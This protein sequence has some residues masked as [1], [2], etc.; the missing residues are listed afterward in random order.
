MTNLV[1]SLRKLKSAWREGDLKAVLKLADSLPTDLS[2]VQKLR[3]KAALKTEDWAVVSDAALHLVSEEPGLVLTAAKTLLRKDKASDAA[4][5][6][7]QLKEHTP[8]RHE[9]AEQTATVLLKSGALASQKGDARKAAELWCLGAKLSPENVALK[10]KLSEALAAAVQRAKSLTTVR[11]LDAYVDAWETV[12]SIDPEN[13]AAAKRLVVVAEQKSN[14]SRAFALWARL[15]NMEPANKAIPLRL[16]KAAVQAGDEAKALVRLHVAGLDGS[17]DNAVKVLRRRVIAKIKQDLIDDDPAAAAEKFNAL[18][19]AQTSEEDIGR[20]PA[21]IVVRLTRK[22]RDARKAGDDTTASYL[23]NLLL[24][25]DESNALALSTAARLSLQSRRFED[26]AK[27]YE[28][29]LAKK[30]DFPKAAQLLERAKA[31]IQLAHIAKVV[32]ASS[33]SAA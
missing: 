17:D 27:L 3:L 10:R 5:L 22:L 24:Q 26:A 13:I 11:G 25:I 14:A 1:E 31:H 9:V 7:L 23:A 29:L 33:R 28:R 8:E 18:A 20:L 19:K 30:P 16:T 32:S 12:L 6:L 2:G 4:L 15:L 21:S